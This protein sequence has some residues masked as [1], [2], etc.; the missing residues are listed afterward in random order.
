MKSKTSEVVDGR[1]RGD[2]ALLRHTP[3]GVLLA[4]LLALLAV[5]R[6]DCDEPQGVETVGATHAAHASLSFP[7]EPL[8]APLIVDPKEPHFYASFL[9]T[10]AHA[11]DR[12]AT[13]A[14]VG[15]GEEF[16]LWGERENGRGWQIS[17]QAGVLAQLHMDPA[18][19]YALINADYIVGIPLEWRHE[20]VSARLRLYHQSSHVGDEYLLLNPGAERVNVSFEE[21]EAIA[22]YDL[23]GCKGRLYTGGGILLHRHP[24][25]NRARVLAGVEWRGRSHRSTF[26]QRHR[27]KTTPIAGVEVKA[28]GELGW[29]PNVRVVAGAE[30]ARER[31]TRAV[32]LLAEYYH[33]YFPY[34]QFFEEKVDHFG[35]GVHLAF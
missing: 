13:L 11:T 21:L 12:S 23:G 9:R 33:G 16:G 10:R 26:A 31:G 5:P 18:T 25:M 7:D 15:F 2:A 28:F 24:A 29:Q 19:S 27:F 22:A 34:G 8:F 32:R 3:P 4:T 14:S 20:R 1:A 6:A 35:A 17:I 30:L